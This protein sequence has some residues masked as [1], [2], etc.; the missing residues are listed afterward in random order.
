MHDTRHT[1]A[2]EPEPSERG[3]GSASAWLTVVGG[4][5]CIAGG[6]IL[7]VF[8]SAGSHGYSLTGH[9]VFETV[10]HGVGLYCMGK[11]LLAMASNYRIGSVHDAIVADDE[12][13]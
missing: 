8:E 13:P 11:G 6:I 2:S 3:A 4:V 10:A 5:V 12:V 9:N 7:L 1:Q